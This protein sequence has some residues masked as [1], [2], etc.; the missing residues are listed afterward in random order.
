MWTLDAC[1]DWLRLIG[2][3]VRR[4]ARE[5][6]QPRISVHR[7][8]WTTTRIDCLRGLLDAHRN[9]QRRA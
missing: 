3:N 5:Y 7:D 1:I 4:R 6:R 9:E 8:D 2:D